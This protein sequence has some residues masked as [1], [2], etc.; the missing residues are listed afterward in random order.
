MELAA[1]YVYKI[2]EKK[3][4]SVAAKELFISQ[5]ALSASV[6]RLEREL[7]FRIFDRSTVPLSL[8]PE[9]RIY[10]DA[11]KEML[12]SERIMQRRLRQLSDLTYGSL[13]IGGSS[14]ISY[15]VLPYICKAFYQQYP[16]ITLDLDLGNVGEIDNL[17]EKLNQHEL[18]LIFTYSDSFDDCVCVP[19]LQERLMIAMHRSLAGAEVLEKYAVS[20]EQILNRSYSPDMEIEDLSVFSNVPFLCFDKGSPTQKR[21]DEMLGEYQVSSYSIHNARHSVMHYNM[22]RA[23]LG[24]LLTIDLLISEK[25]AFSGEFFYFVPKSPVSHR[26]LYLKCAKKAEQNPMIKRFLEIA[27]EVVASDEWR[28]KDSL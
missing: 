4:F 25:D 22:M 9:G 10:I 13:S 3:S 15:H 20:G 19:L 17:F 1:K 23:G 12:E 6:A 11:L 26:T 21:L 8:T 24:A 27:K 16:H 28:H 5:P 14:Y 2:Y 18:D 7:G